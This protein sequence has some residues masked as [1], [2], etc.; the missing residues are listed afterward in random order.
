ML[1]LVQ[2]VNAILSITTKV[3]EDLQEKI[4]QQHYNN[5]VYSHPRITRTIELIRQ[6]YNFNKIKEKVTK[7]IKKCA[8][9]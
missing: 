1:G 4:I 8:D 2:T 6:N 9:C 7:F 3:L 5:L